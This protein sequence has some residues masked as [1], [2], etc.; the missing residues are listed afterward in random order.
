MVRTTK[1]GVLKDEGLLDV[2]TCTEK[3]VV[4]G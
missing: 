4:D 1:D 3:G 2:K